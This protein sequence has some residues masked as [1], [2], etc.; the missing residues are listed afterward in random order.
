MVAALEA[1]IACCSH[2][3]PTLS[4]KHTNPHPARA[5]THSCEDRG[6]QWGK[7][8]KLT[9][10]ISKDMNSRFLIADPLFRLRVC[11]KENSNVFTFCYGAFCSKSAPKAQPQSAQLKLTQS[12]G[13][14]YPNIV[15]TAAGNKSKS[16]KA[17]EEVNA[18]PPHCPS[19]QPELAPILLQVPRG[20]F[21]IPAPL[22]LTPLLGKLLNSKN[23]YFPLTRLGFW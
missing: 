11:M 16:I 2:L 4:P 14:C 15:M 10:A 23:S 12:F 8:F 19:P 9:W 13:T 1:V 17:S 6:Q 3:N 20:Q 18:E 7:L 22:G 21:G 5:S